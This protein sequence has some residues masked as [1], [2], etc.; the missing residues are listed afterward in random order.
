MPAQANSGQLGEFPPS[1]VVFLLYDYNGV[2]SCGGCPKSPAEAVPD[3]R[4]KFEIRSIYQDVSNKLEEQKEENEMMSLVSQFVK[5][6]PPMSRPQAQFFIPAI[7]IS[8]DNSIVLEK[9]VNKCEEFGFCKVC[10]DVAME[11]VTR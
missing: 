5:R 1:P 7:D 3:R 9:I 8:L 10:Q 2:L 6:S 4:T 11:A